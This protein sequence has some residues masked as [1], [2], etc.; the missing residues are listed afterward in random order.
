MYP[1]EE[2]ILF[3]ELTL[4]NEQYYCCSSMVKPDKVDCLSSHPDETRHRMEEHLDDLA[5]AI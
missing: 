5:V 2:H 3:Q 1:P 4:R